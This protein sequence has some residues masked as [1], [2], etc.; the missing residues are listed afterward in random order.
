MY[1][2][3]VLQVK[4]EAQL[5]LTN[6]RDAFRSQSRSPNLVLFDMLGV[7]V[8]CLMCCVFPISLL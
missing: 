7:V 1:G 8:A 5:M 3:L 2:Q 4:E 6:P